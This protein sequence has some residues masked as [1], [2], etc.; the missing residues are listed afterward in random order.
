MSKTRPT[1]RSARPLG[2]ASP[3]EI[4]DLGFVPVRARLIE[5]AAF[6]DRAER[7]AAADDFRCAALREAAALLV[8]GR[9]ERARRILEKLS[10]PTTQPETVSSGKAALGAWRPAAAAAGQG[11]GKV[12]KGK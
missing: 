2:T 5:V 9:P 3:R 12:R 7:Y 11:K 1:R 6:L 4:V 10:D 8:D